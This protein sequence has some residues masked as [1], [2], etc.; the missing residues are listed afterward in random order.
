M[1]HIAILVSVLAAAF[2]SGCATTQRPSYTVSVNGL[3]TQTT[4]VAASFVILPGNKDVDATDLQFQEYAGFVERALGQRDLHRAPSFE[5]A[6]MAIF[7]AYGIS[8]PKEHVYSYSLPHF[9]QTGV[10]SSTTYGN[11]YGNSYSGTTYYTP[12]YGITGYSS[13]VGT[14]VTFT[15][16]IF[17]EAVDLPTYRSQNKIVQ[18]WKTEIVSVGSSGDL[19]RVFPVMI[20]AASSY[21][22]TNT[23]EIRTVNL[24]EDDP[25]VLLVKGITVEQKK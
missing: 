18:V 11:I 14:Y 25:R 4:N 1:K 13:H 17:I 16:H 23:G 22:G 24:Y 12:T 8:D 2:L 21:M 15:R 19:R 5:E 6:D 7:L 3:A 9:G 20:G 10:S